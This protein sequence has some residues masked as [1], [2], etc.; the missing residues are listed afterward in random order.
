MDDLVTAA[1]TQSQTKDLK[2]YDSMID[3]AAIAR[4]NWRL[5]FLDITN[6]SATQIEKINFS[7][8]NPDPTG[9]K[10]SLIKMLHREGV[11]NFDTDAFYTSLAACRWNK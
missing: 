3:N 9:N 7:L 2:L 1:V 6:L 5:M 4:R 10:L 11:H 8:E